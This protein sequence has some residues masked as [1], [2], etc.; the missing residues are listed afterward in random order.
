MKIERVGHEHTTN[1]WNGVAELFAEGE[2]IVASVV[3]V[4]SIV[5]PMAKLSAMLVLSMPR[6]LRSPQHRAWVYR[7]VE[8]IGRWGMVDV[9]LVALLVAAVKLGSWLEVTPG[10]GLIAFCTVVVLS[11]ISTALFDPHAIWEDEG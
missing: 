4:C 10:P 8:F 2:W 9:L 6:V 5:A 3:L 11:L 1:I 7:L